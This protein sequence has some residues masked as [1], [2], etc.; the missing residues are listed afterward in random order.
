[1]D[2]RAWWTEKPEKLGGGGGAVAVE[3]GG[4]VEVWEWRGGAEGSG[5]G[6]EAE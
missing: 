3:E 2:K 4:V 6:E 5:G 1:M